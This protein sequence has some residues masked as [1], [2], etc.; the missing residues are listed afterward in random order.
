M[1]PF[2]LNDEQ[3]NQIAGGEVSAGIING[4]LPAPVAPYTSHYVGEEGGNTTLALGEEGGGY[5]V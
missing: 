4:S 3:L 1:H 2:S 5:E